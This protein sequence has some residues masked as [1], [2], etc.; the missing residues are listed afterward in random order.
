MTR[1][2]IYLG[3]AALTLW[4]CAPALDCEGKSCRVLA[5]ASASIGGVAVEGGTVYWAVDQGVW[6]Q[7]EGCD[8]HLIARRS[9]AP[10][11]FVAKAGALYWLEKGQLFRMFPSGAPEPLLPTGV[12]QFLVD[13][14][15]VYWRTQTELRTAS[16]SGGAPRVLYSQSVRF[17]D[18]TPLVLDGDFLYWVYTSHEA[19]GV[20]PWGNALDVGSRTRILRVSLSGGAVEAVIN[21]DP[22]GDGATSVI[23]DLVVSEDA[24]FWMEHDSL[25]S[26][27]A[28]HSAT[29]D[30]KSAGLA[31]EF[32]D[33]ASIGRRLLLT[34]GVFYWNQ[35]VKPDARFRC[36]GFSDGALCPSTLLRAR[37]KGEPEEVLTTTLGPP[38]KLTVSG[39]QLYYFDDKALV[40]SALA[41]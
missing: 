18:D 3:T 36:D 11:Q 24:L 9:E 23:E 27:S 39:A 7:E 8:A 33:N 2:L 41:P 22:G 12:E 35:Q 6:S 20:S 25:S 34:Q 30:G 28:I 21:L 38:S 26:R 32:G 4:G 10:E 17:D 29:K 19:K 15:Q 16:V 13:K 5:R 40:R 31:L 1:G 37:A 14:G